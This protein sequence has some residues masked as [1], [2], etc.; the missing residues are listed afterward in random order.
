IGRGVSYFWE[1][2]E[3]PTISKELQGVSAKIGEDA[4]FSCELSQS[5]L[6]VK[7]SKDGK[8]IR[9]SQKY[10]IS[11]EQTLVKLTI[12]NVTEKDSGEYSCEITGGP[13]SKVTVPTTVTWLKGTK[14]IRAGGRYELMQKGTVLILKVK[15]LEKSDSEVYTCDIGSMKSTA[16]LTVKGKNLAFAEK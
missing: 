8:S 10:E 7:W 4:T 5:G 15:D 2:G 12:R 6:E 11:Q 16:K 13:T 1:P 9:K 3:A 14:E